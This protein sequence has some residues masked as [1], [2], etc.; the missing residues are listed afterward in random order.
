MWAWIVDSGV[1]DVIR[2]EVMTL[3]ERWI[4]RY[5]T[6]DKGQSQLITD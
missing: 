1:V 4:Q 6:R 5:R 3:L 2:M